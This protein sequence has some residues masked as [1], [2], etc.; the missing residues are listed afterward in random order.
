M[1][2]GATI[3]WMVCTHVSVPGSI[4]EKTVSFAL[5]HETCVRQT[6]AHLLVTV[7]MGGTRTRAPVTLPPLATAALW[8]VL[9]LLP[10]APTLVCTAARASTRQI[11]PTL[12][13]A[14]RGSLAPTVRLI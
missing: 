9:L 8:V 6:P 13:L 5:S 4:M 1:E 10:A 11:R 12:A 3:W 2:E 14:L 7:P